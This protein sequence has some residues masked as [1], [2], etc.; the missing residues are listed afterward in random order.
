MESPGFWL[1]AKASQNI[2][3]SSYVVGNVHL[4]IYMITI[5]MKM[6]K[7]NMQ[8]TLQNILYIYIYIC[9]YIYAV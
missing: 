4:Y 6:L 5:V 9:V 8:N 3:F 1:L 7:N 2:I